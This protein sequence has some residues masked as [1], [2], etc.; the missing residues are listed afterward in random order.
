MTHVLALMMID[1]KTHISGEGVFKS[2]FQA[3]ISKQAIRQII[4]VTVDNLEI[5]IFCDGNHPACS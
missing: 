4:A 3:S 5:H 2:T 1:L